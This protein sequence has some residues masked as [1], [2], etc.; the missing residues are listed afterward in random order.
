[1]RGQYFSNDL[2]QAK[3]D[4]S[5]VVQ[6]EPT[7]YHAAHPFRAVA[8]FGGRKYGFVLDKQ[9]ANSK[10][11]DRLYFD[12]N[13]NGD[14]TDDVP[15]D[16]PKD[17]K[18]TES[19]RSENGW[20][21]TFYLFPRVDFRI[22][23]A[24]TEWD[25][26]FFLRS[27]NNSR[28]EKELTSYARLYSAAYRQG[29]ITL[30][31]RKHTIILVDR[32]TNGR[33][34]VLVGFASDGRGDAG[35]VSQYGTEILFD[36]DILIDKPLGYGYITEHRL[37]LARMNALGGRFCK[38]KV[39][40]GGD[41]L[42]CTPV[43]API[44]KI[45]VPQPL[46][47]VW[48]INEQGFLA[49]DLRND[50]PVAIPAGKWHLT[51]FTLGHDEKNGQVTEQKQMNNKSPSDKVVQ[52]ATKDT[53]IREDAGSE[54]P[55][56]RYMS[57]SCGNVCEPITIIAGQTTMLKVGPPYTPTLTVTTQGKVASLGLEVRGIGQE[58]I[59]FLSGS[60]PPK[61]SFTITDPQ[62]KVVEQGDF[63]YG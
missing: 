29:E 13:G 40:P 61:P 55:V 39:T 24:G 28:H 3:N 9:T 27:I 10:G 42:T 34:D 17:S 8:K 63:E 26:S 50:T 23:A 45:T 16:V 21:G 44:G 1:V 36:P 20:T 31:G 43:A 62:G 38:I 46:C 57:A 32:N 33:F 12:L 22:H 49:L 25:Y 51:Y 18:T 59:Y 4:F 35:F 5:R 37:F 52:H 54:S 7:K 47:N 60:P 53:A 48:L 2:Q 6:R 58:T 11:Y 14:L 15:I 56:I 19:V 41:E 30:G